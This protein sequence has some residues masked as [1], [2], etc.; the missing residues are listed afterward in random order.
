M[1][2]MCLLTAAVFEQFLSV[3]CFYDKELR[4]TNSKIMTNTVFK[5]I[6]ILSLFFAFTL[7][8]S[9]QNAELV[10]KNM[11]ATEQ[12]AKSASRFQLLTLPYA[13][14]ALEP[15]IS[16]ETMALHHGKHLKGYVDNL[17]R[18]I[19]GTEFEQADLNT[20]VRKSEGAI[21]NNAG[22]TL[23]HNLYFTQFAPGKGGEPKGK[24]AETIKKQ[25][26]SFEQFKEQMSKA[27]V[28][29]FGSGWAWLASDADGVLYIMQ[30]SNAGNP[31]RK[32][33]NPILGFDVWEHSYYLSYQN[34][35]ADHIRDLW[36]IIDWDIVS[37]RY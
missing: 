17:N 8:A 24:L 6:S 30:E 21:F 26:G 28:S 23:N 5:S 35:R 13:L 20:I 27:A 4:N 14:D 1:D 9:S 31:V 3:C 32:G 37:S 18:L 11:S 36:N 15:A 25:Y 2:G 19:V 33:L 7:L 10:G 12:S 22:Q 29:L 16:A 34:R